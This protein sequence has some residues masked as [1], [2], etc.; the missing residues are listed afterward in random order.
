M[1]ML[2]AKKIYL[3]RPIQTQPLSVQRNVLFNTIGSLT[4]QG[5]LW[6]ITVLVVTI[7]GNYKNAGV[8][9]YAMA[10]GNIFLTI[11]VYAM[12]TYQVSDVE[13]RYTQPNYIA[14]RIVTILIAFIVCAVY[15]IAT[16]IPSGTI[17]PTACY[18]LFKAD[19][20]FSIVCYGA[21]QRSNRMDYIG[22]SQFLRG[23]A[24]LLAF[25]LLLH[26]S[27]SLSIAILGMFAGCCLVTLLYD[28]PHMAAFGPLKASI[29]KEPVFHLLRQCLPGVLATLFLTSVVSITRQRFGILEGTEEL[30]KYA[31]VATPAV[32]IQAM[33][34][35]LYA[36]FIEPI[37]QT[38]NKGDVKVFYSHFLK[39]C[40]TMLTIM[41]ILAVAIVFGGSWFLVRVYGESISPYVYLLP[42]ISIT[43]VQIAFLW[44][45]SD[46]LIV[47]RSFRG[48]LMSNATSFVIALVTMNSFIQAYGMSGINYTLMV[49]YGFG[50]LIAFGSVVICVRQ[51]KRR[52]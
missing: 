45:C 31:S 9:A 16:A 28:L 8:L 6:L 29:S 18:L 15:S 24:A 27:K 38:W 3:G 10:L 11:A 37:S 46:V 51:Q 41:L 52:A 42:Q 4:Y 5:C 1:P 7:S 47:Q 36:P 12:R 40:L 49:S 14:F 13:G 48:V 44:L 20:S 21:E 26:L 23:V 33:A 30:G 34:G 22:I 25:T 39:I 50:L 2:S 35:F 32:I 43:T 17:I 19:E